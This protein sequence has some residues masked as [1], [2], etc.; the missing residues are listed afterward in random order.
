VA[1]KKNT[2]Y[3]WGSWKNPGKLPEPDVWFHD[4]L[5][6]DGTPFRQTEIDFI[7]KTMSEKC[8]RKTLPPQRKRAGRV[9]CKTK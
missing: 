6:K 5:R 8:P 7:K 1:G 2:V 3:S 4:V 9:G